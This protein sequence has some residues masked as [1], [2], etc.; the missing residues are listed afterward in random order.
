MADFVKHFRWNDLV[1]YRCYIAYNE[2]RPLI[3]D[4]QFEAKGTQ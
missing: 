1:E 3:I 2:F 4:R